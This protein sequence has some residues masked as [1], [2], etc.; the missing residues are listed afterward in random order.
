MRRIFFSN[1]N[2]PASLRSEH[3]SS[4]ILLSNCSFMLC[5]CF[6][7]NCFFLCF[8]MSQQ[9]KFSE[10]FSCFFFESQKLLFFSLK[11]FFPLTKLSTYFLSRFFGGEISVYRTYNYIHNITS[12]LVRV[13]IRVQLTC[14]SCMYQNKGFLLLIKFLLFF[15]EKFQ[16]TTLYSLTIVMHFPLSPHDVQQ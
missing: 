8:K 11:N 12:K 9:K 16:F 2:K 14:F 13:R 3:K 15:H 1:N 7:A 5:S 10:N 6:A 4:W